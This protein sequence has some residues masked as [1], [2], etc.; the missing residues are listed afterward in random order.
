MTE[1]FFPRIGLQPIIGTT[2]IY[3][4]G[5]GVIIRIIDNLPGLRKLAD[6]CLTRISATSCSQCARLPFCEA[7]LKEE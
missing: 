1:K 3:K 4:G 7:P 6:V 5:M 2:V